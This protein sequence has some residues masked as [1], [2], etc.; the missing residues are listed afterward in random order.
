MVTVKASKPGHSGLGAGW[1]IETGTSGGNLYVARIWRSILAAM[2]VGFGCDEQFRPLT[3]KK[4]TDKRMRQEG[5]SNRDNTFTWTHFAAGFISKLSHG[6]HL[7]GTD[8]RGLVVDE[9]HYGSQAPLLLGATRSRK[10]LD[11]SSS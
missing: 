11:L 10:L 1:L 9:F 5:M 7:I 3:D 2:S 4:T 6:E 8:P